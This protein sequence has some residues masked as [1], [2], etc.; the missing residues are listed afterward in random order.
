MAALRR[1]H[2]TAPVAFVTGDAASYQVAQVYAEEGAESNPYQ[3]FEDL[4]AAEVWISI[5][6]S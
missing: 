1:V 6:S 5:H 2:G 4:A 3:V